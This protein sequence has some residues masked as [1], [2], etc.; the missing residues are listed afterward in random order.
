MLVPRRI[1]R[2]VLSEP[3][4]VGDKAR[5]LL[6]TQPQARSRDASG[7]WKKTGR[8]GKRGKNGRGGGL[9]GKKRAASKATKTP[10]SRN[11]PVVALAC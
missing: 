3:S 5:C 1:S 11:Y 9:P 10:A 8:L 4:F 2:G 7:D 6:I